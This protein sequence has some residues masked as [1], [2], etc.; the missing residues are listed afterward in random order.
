MELVK[1]IR[2]LKAEKQ[3]LDEAI[4]A[5]ERLSRNRRRAGWPTKW[6]EGQ[7]RHPVGKRSEKP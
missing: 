6:L 3:R 4:A 1:M 2:E 7:I 5:L